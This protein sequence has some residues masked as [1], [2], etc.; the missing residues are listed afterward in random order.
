MAIEVSCLL[1]WKSF[2][3]SVTRNM[4]VLSLF[5]WG[6]LLFQYRTNILT[7]LC[8]FWSYLSY[9]S[10]LNYLSYV[11]IGSEHG[12]C[13]IIWSPVLI[14]WILYHFFT[15]KQCIFKYFYRIFRHMF[16]QSLGI[17]ITFQ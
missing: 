14:C 11:F 8:M 3:M 9:L 7:A 1:D 12:N 2:A 17:A 4:L 15:V 13:I 6:D 5:R 16:Q 10:I